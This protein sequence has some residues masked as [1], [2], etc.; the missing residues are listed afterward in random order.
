MPI[1]IFE[2]LQALGVAN[3]WAFQFITDLYHRLDGIPCLVAKEGELTLECS[4]PTPC[5]NCQYRVESGKELEQ[6]L[7]EYCI[8]NEELQ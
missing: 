4:L 2:M 7:T 5:R 3:V 6:Y 1:K 8:Q